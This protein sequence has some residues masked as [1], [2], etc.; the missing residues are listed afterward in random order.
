M[1]DFNLNVAIV[2]RVTKGQAYVNNFG[3]RNSRD[4]KIKVNLTQKVNSMFTW[5]LCFSL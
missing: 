2:F 4:Y 1:G 3:R 5:F